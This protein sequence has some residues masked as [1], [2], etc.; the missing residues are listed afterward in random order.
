[1]SFIRTS[2]ND[3]ELLNNW[4]IFFINMF[5]RWLRV[6]LDILVF[7]LFIKILKFYV[8]TKKR[9][10]QEIEYD[11][12]PKQKFVTNWAVSVAI[13]NLYRSLFFGINGILIYYPVEYMNGQNYF[14]SNETYRTIA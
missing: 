11:F 14:N 5:L 13:M 8:I 1:M 4:T 3:K 7:A 9:R 12:T 10:L 2:N 6:S